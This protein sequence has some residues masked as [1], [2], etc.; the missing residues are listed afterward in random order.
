[1]QGHYFNS[2]RIIQSSRVHRVEAKLIDQDRLNQALIAG[3]STPVL[4]VAASLSPSSAGYGTHTQLGFG[5]CVLL[6]LT[7]WPCP[8]CG[9]TTSFTHMANG[10]VVQA[11]FTQPMG[12]VLFL[13]TLIMCTMAWSDLLFRRHLI[14]QFFERLT[15]VEPVIYW[16]LLAGFALGWVYKS[17]CML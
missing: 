10:H 14:K 2:W 11:F 7:S 17:R 9:M 5:E 15:V 3:A 16:V 13:I 4:L 12:V 8:M 6:S 1:M